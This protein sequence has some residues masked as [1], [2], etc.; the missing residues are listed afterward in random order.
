ML[1]EPKI[2]EAARM[3]LRTCLDMGMVREASS[4]TRVIL[5]RK[6]LLTPEHAHELH[7][8]VLCHAV[9]EDDYSSAIKSC[10][11]SVSAH[12]NSVE[13]VNSLN[14]LVRKAP[15]GDVNRP[16][17]RRMASRQQESLPLSLL[18]GNAF[19][20]SRNYQMALDKFLQAY[21]LAPEEPLVSL[22]ISAL[23]MRVL[24][25]RKLIDRHGCLVKCLPFLERY[26]QLRREEE[27]EEMVSLL[28]RQ[29]Q[30]EKA[31]AGGGGGV[32]GGG[33]GSEEQP[34]AEEMDEAREKAFALRVATKQ[35]M[36]QEV[37]YNMGRS[38][39]QASLNHIAVHFYRDALGLHD[40][41][42]QEFALLGSKGHVTREA[43]YNLVSIYQLANNRELA[44]HV[45]ENY[46]TVER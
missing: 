5:Q 34:T 12:P 9:N 43:A 24:T 22:A 31:A 45:A 10:L 7:E 6:N 40:A 21:R 2:F 28:V 19:A 16:V 15:R 36:Q 17:I 8:F 18:S 1:G 4:L 11:V 35:A 26:A 42:P 39:H 20:I 30:Q 44:R 23:L 27:P 33:G 3:I 14:R 29:Q 37:V 13:L 32:G 38:F 25:H 46:L 41:H